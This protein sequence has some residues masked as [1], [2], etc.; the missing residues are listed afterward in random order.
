MSV[1]VMSLVWDNF[2]RGGSEKLAMLALADWCNDQGGSLHPSIAGIAKKINTSESQARRII[3]KFIDEGYL[4]VVANH[5]GGNPGQS[6]HYK[7][8]IKK[9]SEGSTDATPSMDA[10]PSTDATPSMDARDPLHGCARP[11]APMTPEPPLTINKPSLK[12]KI[13]K[14]ENSAINRPDDIPEQIWNDFLVLRKLKKA[15]VTDTALNGIRKEATKAKIRIADALEICCQNGWAGFKAEWMQR[16]Q[17]PPRQPS[18]QEMATIAARSFFKNQGERHEREVTGTAE[19][20]EP[21]SI[22][23]SMD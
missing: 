17:A 21:E 11:L 15:P 5:D 10:T 16:Q 1:K 18:K 12:E 3:H 22:V 6:R 4:T 13:N 23:R 2:N 8:N 20:I 9:L 14:K 19:F 7:L